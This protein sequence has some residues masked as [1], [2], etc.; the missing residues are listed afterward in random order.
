MNFHCR[1]SGL[2]HSSRLT[3]W[4]I[5]LLEK[6]TA[7]QSVKKFP[8]FYGTRRFITAFTSS[9]HLSVSRGRSI[10]SMPP[11][12]FLKIHLNIIL[13]STPGSSKWSLP[14]RFPHQNPV[15]TSPLPHMGYMLSRYIYEI[16][17]SA[18]CL[19]PLY[20]SVACCVGIVITI[21]LRHCCD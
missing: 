14:L 13:P 6:L 19:H 2:S 4:S 20:A 11:F 16:N 18:M 7:R 21:L 15:Y 1:H 10:Q 17:N 5:I 9:R 3:P 8:T 12:H